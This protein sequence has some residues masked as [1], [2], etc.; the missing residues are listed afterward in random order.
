MRYHPLSYLSLSCFPLSPFRLSVTLKMVPD[1]P[2]YLLI[3][4][5]EGD[6]YYGEK[7]MDYFRRKC[8]TQNMW[9]CH[10]AG[11][12]HESFEQDV[13]IANDRRHLVEH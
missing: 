4:C 12:F 9:L 11:D 8:R 10:F 1:Y 13:K 2:Y 3:I 6:G 5:A 7:I